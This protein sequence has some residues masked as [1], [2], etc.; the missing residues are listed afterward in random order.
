MDD[1]QREG[2]GCFL[3][4]RPPLANSIE[5]PPLRGAIATGSRRLRLSNDDDDSIAS[6]APSMLR[7][8]VVDAI[9][10]TDSTATRLEAF[11]RR[12][13]STENFRASCRSFQSELDHLGASVRELDG[14]WA[15]KDDDGDSASLSSWKM[16]NTAASSSGD[17][18]FDCEGSS[19]NSAFYLD[20][21]DGEIVRRRHFNNISTLSL[22][23]DKYEEKREALIHPQ[24]QCTHPSFNE[25][26]GDACLSP[27]VHEHA[28]FDAPASPVGTEISFCSSSVNSMDD[29]EPFSYTSY[30]KPMELRVDDDE[31]VIYDGAEED[32]SREEGSLS[33][34]SISEATAKLRLRSLAGFGALP[35]KENREMI[36]RKN[37]CERSSLAVLLRLMENAAEKLYG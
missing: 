29:N 23:Q 11:L 13:D 5:A 6:A 20:D 18:S 33:N 3:K 19:V 10:S 35:G 31:D 22:E 37:C 7:R 24:G 21:L 14:L 32:I 1:C 30:P 2:R 8:S 16:A 34:P 28:K 12:I 9:A 36:A 4:R 27:V 25:K 17:S 15:R 26:A